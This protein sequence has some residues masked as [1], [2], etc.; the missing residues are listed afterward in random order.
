[1]RLAFLLVPLVSSL[2]I[3]VYF[4]LYTFSL[5]SIDPHE[6]YKGGAGATS[7]FPVPLCLLTFPLL[8]LFLYILSKRPNTHPLISFPYLSFSKNFFY[9]L[10]IVYLFLCSR[11]EL[12]GLIKGIQLL[13]PFLIIPLFPVFSFKGRLSSFLLKA[14]LCSLLLFV[15]LHL[16]SYFFYTHYLSSDSIVRFTAFWDSSIYSAHVSWS[17][18]LGVLL[19]FILLYYLA[20]RISLLIFLLSF[21]I[22]AAE[23]VLSTRRDPF[24]AFVSFISVLL[25]YA[26]WRITASMRLSRPALFLCLSF[27]IL[28]PIIAFFYGNHLHYL[29]RIFDITDRLAVWEIVS[30]SLLSPSFILTGMMFPYNNLHS[31]PLSLLYSYGLIGVSIICLSLASFISLVAKLNKA[32][33]SSIKFSGFP[34]YILILGIL[35][36]VIPSNLVNVSLTQP[37]YLINLIFLFLLFQS[38]ISSHSASYRYSSI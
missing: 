12:I 20:N 31:Y 13:L 10:L 19:T 2:P 22:V 23:L 21:S 30:S 28:S 7:V 37:F 35:S 14:Y 17:S 18:Y 5:I 38:A 15:S 25:L 29:N 9:I 32:H 24:V 33:L 36:A 1:M 11:F 8:L 26:L 34:G 3:P 16:Y 4:D 27:A 6:M